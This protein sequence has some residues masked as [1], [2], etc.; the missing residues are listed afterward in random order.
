M[1]RGVSNRYFLPPDIQNVPTNFSS[2]NEKIRK[3]RKKKSIAFQAERLLDTYIWE[4]LL[5]IFHNESNFHS[6]KSVFLER[7]TPKNHEIQNVWNK[8]LIF[9]NIW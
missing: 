5:D 7:A 2:L 4:L 3:I 9:E 8:F 6:R 1:Y